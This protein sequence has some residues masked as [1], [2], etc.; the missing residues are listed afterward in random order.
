MT[1]GAATRPTVAASTSSPAATAAL[2]TAL[3]PLLE[4][5]DVILLDGDLGAGK[6]TFMQGLAAGLGVDDNVTSPTFTLMNIYPTSR[7]V[8]LVH[9]DAYRLENLSEVIDLALTEMLEDGA[10]VAIEWGDRARAA[11]ADPVLRIA[12]QAPDPSDPDRRSIELTGEGP[13]WPARWA[14]VEQAVEQAV[15]SAR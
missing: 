14:A 4:A 7:G 9:V 1:A 15:G 8:D 12:M 6:T 5:G 2:A 10:I 13:G 11:L 3:A